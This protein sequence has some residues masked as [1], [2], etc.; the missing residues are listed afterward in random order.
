MSNHVINRVL[1]TLFILIVVLF[2]TAYLRPNIIN[3][4]QRPNFTRVPCEEILRRSPS[5]KI[6]TGEV[7]PINTFSYMVSIQYKEVLSRHYCGGTLLNSQWILTA[8]HCV[9]DRELVRTIFII[10]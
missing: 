4:K 10:I 3:T 5:F 1:K 9:T 7:T 2:Q 8:A 6:V